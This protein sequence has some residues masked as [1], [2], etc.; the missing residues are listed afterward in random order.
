MLFHQ[1]LLLIVSQVTGVTQADILSRSRFREICIAKQLYAHFLRQKFKLKLKDISNI[2]HCHYATV[3]HSTNL[4]NDLIWA[5]DKV[6]IGYINEID[7]SLR[8][9]D[10]LNFVRKIKVYAPIDCDMEGLKLALIEQF[11]CSIEFVY[12]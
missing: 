3:L 5:K 8:A 2:M 6:I 10:G 11:G 1:Q 7:T 4:I 9:L 12:E